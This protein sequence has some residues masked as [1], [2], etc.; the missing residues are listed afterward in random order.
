MIG[1][2]SKSHNTIGNIRKKYF[3]EKMQSPL[4]SPPNPGLT[5]TDTARCLL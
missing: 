3:A 4:T 5:D 1:S 2:T